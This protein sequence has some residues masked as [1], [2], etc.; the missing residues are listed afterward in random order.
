MLWKVSDGK[1]QQKFFLQ[2]HFILKKSFY[3]KKSFF[4]GGKFQMVS[5]DKYLVVI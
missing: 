1:F 3:L 5:L 2:I 4:F